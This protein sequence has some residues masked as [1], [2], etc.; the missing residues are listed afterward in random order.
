MAWFHSLLADL[1]TDA[2]TKLL[3]LTPKELEYLGCE[4][5]GRQMDNCTAAFPIDAEGA[6]RGARQAMTA[7][8]ALAIDEPLDVFAALFGL[9]RQV[10]GKGSTEGLDCV[11]C[12]ELWILTDL[13]DDLLRHHKAATE[14][15]RNRLRAFTHHQKQ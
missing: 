14:E 9:V 7:P 11:D 12:T 2:Q 8:A 5:R 10:V 3:S 13:A 6:A 1:P 15:A 4:I